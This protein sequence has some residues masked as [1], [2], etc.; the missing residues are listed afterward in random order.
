M[1]RFNQLR[2]ILEREGIAYRHKVKN[3]MGQVERSDCI[4]R[5]DGKRRD[6]CRRYL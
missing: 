4:E 5:K 1:K 2:D 3:R 6:V